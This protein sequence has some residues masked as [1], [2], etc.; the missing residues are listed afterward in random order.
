MFYIWEW[1]GPE[2]FWFYGNF[3]QERHVE[4]TISELP[5]GF[6]TKEDALKFAKKRVNNYKLI[7]IV[8]GEVKNPW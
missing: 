3:V 1:T 4:S 5:V 8:G 7:E 6:K 2:R